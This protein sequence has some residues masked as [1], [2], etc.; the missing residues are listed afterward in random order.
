MGRLHARRGSHFI[1]E[2]PREQRNACETHEQAFQPFLGAFENC[3][4]ALRGA[5]VRTGRLYEIPRPAL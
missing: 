5:S 1:D 2:P 4:A 3:S